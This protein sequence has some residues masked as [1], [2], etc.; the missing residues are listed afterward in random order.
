MATLAKERLKRYQ[1]EQAT[2]SSNLSIPFLKLP[3]GRT[4]VRILPGQDPGSVDKDFY[5]KSI[6]HYN[7]NPNN[8]KL[9]VISPKSKNPNAYCPIMERVNQLRH[10]TD[11]ADQAEVKRMWPKTFY[12]MGLVMLEGPDAGKLFV[13]QGRKTLWKKIMSLMNEPDYGDITHPVEGFDVVLVKSGKDLD[14][15]YDVLPS[16]NPSPIS[17]DPEEVQQ[18]LAN[19]FDLWR[20]R[21]APDADEIKAF[22]RGE[23][24]RFSSGGFGTKPVITKEDIPE[25]VSDE[26]DE[27]EEAPTFIPPPVVEKPTRV[28]ET[29]KLEEPV[30]A[31]KPPRRVFNSNL[32]SIREKLNKS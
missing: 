27:E 6:V 12:Y 24:S 21:E 25:G 22:M 32:N 31:P 11:P 8:P 30:E 15:E 26:V 4:K 17:D 13:L 18:I 16:R 3:V 29:A 10:S 1:D 14:T 9:P 23:I 19:Q 7:V 2:V 28:V 20:F 5:V